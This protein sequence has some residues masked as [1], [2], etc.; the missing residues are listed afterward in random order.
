MTKKNT[1]PR[2]WF[3]V[4]RREGRVT[5]GAIVFLSALGL[6]LFGIVMRAAPAAMTPTWGKVLI[7]TGYGTRGR[8]LKSTELYDPATN[9][10]AAA[11]DTPIMTVDCSG[12][13]ATL[14]LSGEALL[15]GGDI[16]DN[17]LASTELY[18]PATN[19]FS[20]NTA[21]MN[22][23]RYLATATLLLS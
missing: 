17:T 14:L 13:T 18:D 23:A 8:A 11:D 4:T 12:S 22:V 16:N 1:H 5:V 15:A 10:F 7:A 20:S 19:S 21:T 3:D 2:P 6:A 9:R